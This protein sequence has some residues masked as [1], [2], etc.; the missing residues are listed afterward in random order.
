MD[1]IINSIANLLLEHRYIFA[2]LAAWFEG[3]YIMIVAG[4]LYKFG[5]FKFWGL[6]IVLNAGYFVSGIMYYVIGRIGGN[7]VLE[8]IGRRMHLTNK[9]LLKL[10]NYFKKH[11][12]KAIVITRITYGLAI[13]VLII[14][15]SFKMKWKKFLLANLISTLIWVP[16]AFAIG[17]VFGI[18]YSALGKITRSIAVGLTIVLFI[19]IVFLSFFVFHWLMRKAKLKFMK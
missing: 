8:K 19:A 2:F 6:M 5:F 14:A 13:P 16:G 3:N 15:G 11:S 1:L 17:Y 18:S 10:E 7:K 4:V 9:L 12:A